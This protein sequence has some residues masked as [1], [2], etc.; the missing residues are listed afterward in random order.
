MF[1]H[2]AARRRLLLHFCFLF[3]RF[4]V[5]THSRAEAAASHPI[6]L[7]MP[8][9]LF[10]HTAAR[11]RLLQNIHPV[12]QMLGFQHTAA[13]RRLPLNVEKDNPITLVST[14]SRAEAAADAVIEQQQRNDVSTHSRAEAA[15]SRL[16]K[17][18]GA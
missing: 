15:A 3:R 18:F 17:R 9:S 4:S 16:D 13:R 6:V 12:V 11:R 8:Q 5:S 7:S 14:H 1:Q 2:A 10:Q